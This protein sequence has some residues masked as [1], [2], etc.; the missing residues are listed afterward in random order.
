M[1]LSRP[2]RVPLALL[3]LLSEPKSQTSEELRLLLQPAGR[4]DRVYLSKW[5]DPEQ[6]HTAF[7]HL[8]RGEP[9]V[10]AYLTG[11]LFRT[12]QIVEFRRVVLNL[13]R[14]NQAVR[15]RL[16]SLLAY[17]ERMGEAP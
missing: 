3:R 9:T 17:L 7:G 1:R 8:T 15:K 4:P 6:L 11:R 2:Y 16:E 12:S 14:R 5:Y 10:E 13:N